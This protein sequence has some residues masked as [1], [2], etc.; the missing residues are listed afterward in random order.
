ME[1]HINADEARVHDYNLE[2]GR[3]ASI[4]NAS[5]PHRVSD[6]DPLIIGVDF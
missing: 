5:S 1:W 3:D 4:F 6:H 2:F